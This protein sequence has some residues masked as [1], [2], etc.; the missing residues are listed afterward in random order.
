MVRQVRQATHARI[1]SLHTLTPPPHDN[2]AWHTHPPTHL[3]GVEMMWASMMAS[4]AHGPCHK[5]LG[6][7]C[8]RPLLC[9]KKA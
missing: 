6:C 7:A 9:G 1:P 2:N 4:S 3:S 8:S 5:C